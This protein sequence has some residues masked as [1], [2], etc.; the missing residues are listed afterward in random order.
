MASE[1][2]SGC[3]RPLLIG[4]IGL[5]LI[6]GFTIFFV[7]TRGLYRAPDVLDQPLV[8]E[9]AQ[10]FDGDS[11][12]PGTPTLVVEQGQITCL[13][14]CEVPTDAR[15]IDGSG[16]SLLPGLI[17]GYARFYAPTQENLS[18]SDLGGLLS[19]IKQRPEVRRHLMA[20]G[21]TTLF[22]AG[23]LPQ[24]I[25][26]LK[27]QQSTGDLAGP[28]IRSAGPDFT[29]QG[30]FPLD[31]Y[32]GNENLEEEAV[33][34]PNSPAKAQQE[35]AKL[36]G[37]GLDA[38]KVV[39][40]DFNGDLPK[41]DRGTL[42]ALIAVADNK[43]AYAVV[44]CGTAEDLRTAAKLGARVLAYGPAAALDSATM[45]LMRA[46]DVV[47][48]PMLARRPRAEHPRLRKNIQALLDAGV[49]IGIGSDPRGEAQQFGRSLHDEL[50]AQVEAGRSHTDALVAA[51]RL[52]ART[53]RIDD[54][55][56]QISPG[57]AADLI[58]VQGRPWDHI[59][60]IRQVRWVIQQGRIM[61]E[62]GEVVE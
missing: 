13:G 36:L 39:Y 8:I 54:R 21:V 57:M 17:D 38:V 48:Y 59:E 26:L 27:D 53:L 25:L 49:E 47:Y 3:L 22:S 37:Y 34:A 28:R 19:F 30:G 44:R 56:G 10:V 58:L 33:R 61:V 51:T 31:L 9:G 23:D 52:N 2:K 18:R 62:Q 41:L 50:I 14:D 15:R 5:T 55:T 24:N 16:M 1:N 29:A 20:A 35:A 42:R 12:L 46:Q 4:I 32:E 60:D 6:S 7:F 45:A 43:G 40:D 11:L